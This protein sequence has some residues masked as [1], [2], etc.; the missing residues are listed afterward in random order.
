MIW[1]GGEEEFVGWIWRLLVTGFH[2][3]HH[4][5][6]YDY[7]TSEWGLRMNVTTGF[8]QLMAW[9]GLAY[10]LRQPSRQTVIA[11]AR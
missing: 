10:D 8:I 2:N 7:S 11:R 4:T 6:P 3:Y 9:L 5:F 1:S